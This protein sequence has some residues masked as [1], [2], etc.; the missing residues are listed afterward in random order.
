MSAGE[1]GGGANSAGGKPG[2]QGPGGNGARSG[3]RAM[4]A[5]ERMGKPQPKAAGPA[6]QP[7]G[8]APGRPTASGS[9][10]GFVGTLAQDALDAAEGKN[11][12]GE[13]RMGRPNLP[14]AREIKPQPKS[15][16]VVQPAPSKASEGKPASTGEM[17]IAGGLMLL[18]AG[19]PA[20]IGGWAAGALWYMAR[21]TPAAPSQVQYPFVSW[22][23][24]AGP[25]GGYTAVTRTIA[26]TLLICLPVAVMLVV[27]AM[28]AGRKKG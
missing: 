7:V 11:A 24:D 17:G 2:A 8:E 4:R 21:V 23:Y 9:A 18:L 28:R 12:S 3:Q 19:V 13:T 6:S 22:N 20:V 15:P 16:G 14:M 26:W 27:I 25:G 5:V 10:T 1:Q